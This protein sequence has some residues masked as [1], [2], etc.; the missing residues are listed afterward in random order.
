MTTQQAALDLRVLVTNLATRYGVTDLNSLYSHPDFKVAYSAVASVNPGVSAASLTAKTI[1]ELRFESLKGQSV[2]AW[3]AEPNHV[4]YKFDDDAKKSLPVAAG[5]ML[6]TGDGE[7]RFI[8]YGPYNPALPVNQ[9]APQGGWIPGLQRTSPITLTGV[10]LVRDH[11]FGTVQVNM[12]YKGKELVSKIVPGGHNDPFPNA[13]TFDTEFGKTAKANGWGAW[14]RDKKTAT[15]RGRYGDGDG[16]GVFATLTFPSEPSAIKVWTS[17][18]DRSQHS[19]KAELQDAL[20][21][22]VTTNLPLQDAL[23]RLGRSPET[24]PEVVSSLLAGR[25]IF[26]RGQGSILSG[27]KPEDLGFSNEAWKNQVEIWTSSGFLAPPP[28]GKSPLRRMWLSKEAKVTATGEQLPAPPYITIGDKKV[29]DIQ[30]KAGNEWEISLLCFDEARK[31]GFQVKPSKKEPKEGRRVWNEDSFFVFLDGL[32]ASE[33][34]DDDPI[35]A[36]VKQS[37]LTLTA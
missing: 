35:L 11:G 21:N 2:K 3:C 20:G 32:E 25:R 27:K 6:I 12:V 23:K 30:E 17:D 15:L 4:M 22:T 29:Y 28:S 31:P 1:N 9:Q 34:P 14:K 24:P 10:D 26:A 37:M 19:I 33:L 16:G 7:T 18:E 36:M 13:P 8:R 5:V